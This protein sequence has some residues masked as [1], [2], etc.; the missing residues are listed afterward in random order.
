[1]Y[2]VTSNYM[3]CPM[4]SLPPSPTC[5]APAVWDYIGY[6]NKG[7]F[8]SIFK[9]VNVSTGMIAAM[10][11][12]FDQ[13]NLKLLVNEAHH[14]LSINTTLRMDA[15]ASHLAKYIPHLLDRG[16]LSN[17]TFYVMPLFGPD[18]YDLKKMTPIKRFTNWTCYYIL[19]ESLLALLALNYCNIV[20]RD[21]KPA[22]FVSNFSSDSINDRSLIL[23]DFGLVSQDSSSSKPYHDHLE[24]KT[25]GTLCYSSVNSQKPNA[26]P[27]FIDDLWSAFYISLENFSG[28]LPWYHISDK[29]QVN[30]MKENLNLYQLNVDGYHIPPILFE[31]FRLLHDKKE[32]KRIAL[33]EKL[34]HLVGCEIKSAML[35]ESI[36]LDWE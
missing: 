14:I 15:R 33:H 5:L 35:H 20:H 9:V 32:H 18:L 8:G 19:R 27:T 1:M 13:A 31:F 2:Q 30:Q 16:C 24:G 22:N 10:K 25:V 17:G 21:L 29:H 11:M 7:T 23:I 36:P 4:P 3:H 12:E 28:T 26:L 6:I 34:I